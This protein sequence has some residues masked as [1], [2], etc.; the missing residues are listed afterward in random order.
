MRL[1][2]LLHL[3]VCRLFKV[4]VFVY[5]SIWTLR[6]LSWRWR[7]P[8]LL[9]QEEDLFAANLENLFLE[10]FPIVLRE[11]EVLRL[12]EVLLEIDLVIADLLRQLLLHW[13][14]LQV[15]PI[16]LRWICNPEALVQNSLMGLQSQKVLQTVRL[17]RFFWVDDLEDPLL[18]YAECKLTLMH[19]KFLNL[20]KR[21]TLASRLA[22]IIRGLQLVVFGYQHLLLILD[23]P[24]LNFIS[25]QRSLEEGTWL[26][27]GL[28]QP[29]LAALKICYL[30]AVPANRKLTCLRVTD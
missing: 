12:F 21:R 18:I 24:F 29:L 20:V 9:R 17:R 5:V 2:Y 6:R 26:G 22:N 8:E 11:E 10:Y 23:F 16:S 28:E 30:K 27:A 4:L 14:R 25:E 7:L 1:V 19:W 3:I 13:R 15:S